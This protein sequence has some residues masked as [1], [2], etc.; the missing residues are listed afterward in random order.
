M[1][2]IF[3]GLA[4]GISFIVY[5]L[6]MADTVPYWDSGEFIA[7]SFILGVPHPP[8]SP[9][10]LIIGRVFSMIPFNPDIAFRINLISPVVSA[11]A[12][13]YLYLSTVK[14]ISN[15]RGKIECSMDAIITFGGSLV[16][17]LTF[18]FTDSQ[19]FNA[20]EAEVYGFSTFFTA[21]VVWL[22]LHWAERADE[23]GNERYILII[24]YMIGLATGV[25]LLNLLALPFI[26]LIIYFKKY[27]FSYKGFLITTAITGV[28]YLII[29]TGII[30]GV[31]KIVNAVG[32]E[33]FLFLCLAIMGGMVFTIIKRQFRYALAL[34]SIVLILV[35]YSSYATIFIRSGQQPAI[36]E[37]DPST[38]PRAIAYMEREQYGQMTQFPRR[39]TGLPP[40]HEVVGRPAKGGRNYSASQERKYKSYR[41]DKQWDYFWSY[42]VK[43]MYWR[44]FLWQ[45]AGRGPSTDDWVTAYGANTKEDGVDWF[46]FGLPLAFLFGLWGMF[47][48]FQKDREQAFSV[49]SLFL[50]MGLAIIIFVNQDN[51][52]PRER[53]YSYVGSFFAFSIWISIAVAALGDKIRLLLKDKSLSNNAVMG[54][55][56]LLIVAMPGMM[57]KANYHEHD[58]SDN[59]LAWDYS[60]NILQSCEPN[61]I[62]FTN[63]DNDTFPLW[64]LQEV[65][66]V[67]TDITIANLSLL[68][69]EWYIRQLR[70]SRRGRV[71][72]KGREL[73][74][75]INLTD[76]QVMEV[77]SGLQPWKA[78]NV[79]IPTPKSNKNKDG[80]IQWKVNPTFAGAALM[81]KD[82]MI[83]KII[84]DAQ[85]NYPIYFAV[86]VPASNRL[87]L[88][89]FL[90]MEGLVYRLRPH[91]VDGRNP[92]NEERMWTN[93]MSG[94]GS[95]IWEQ[96]LE[97]N[98][99]NKVENE[100][101]SKSYKPGYLF[102][103]LGREDVFYF[104][105]TNIRLLQNLRSAY[106]QLAAFH[107]M[108]FKD[109]EMTDKDQS[110]IHR[111]KALEVLVKM[112]DNIPEK[113][114]R[115]DSKDLYYQV[116]RLFGELGNKD[117]LRRILG[118]L[119][120]REDLNIRD[121]LDY[122]QVYISQLDSFEIGQSIFE[123][124]YRDFKDIE[125]GDRRAT[126][127]EM[128]AWRQSFTQI[129]SSLVFTYK[130][131]DM[132]PKAEVVLADWL[133]KNPN[134]PVA[135]KLMEDLKNEEVKSKKE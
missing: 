75:F 133:D 91:N 84:S 44:Y 85:W 32:L 72:Q 103:N 59:R 101:W 45:F 20:V 130:K 88:E 127:K 71:D 39:F 56:V 123:D 40:K 66:G 117:E 65:E 58:R 99:W 105:T 121:R 118:N 120:I 76:P 68:N 53:D 83:L 38:V 36:N 73:E 82:M 16:G 67:R 132:V 3:A 9:L 112:Q 14:L 33:L 135:Q 102:R 69:T 7:T 92:I 106:M 4:L 49:F 86:T 134:D 10:Y 64:Y 43:K 28:I 122:G 46:Q 81:V 60:Y 62:L 27:E 48:H 11:L 98:D 116:G 97:A 80:F 22:I 94:Y 114:I 50:M 89:P 108:A 35:G 115:Y 8:G 37:N 12:V 2:R 51:P 57:V 26:A 119:V 63:G 107:Y 104:P 47:Y 25:H 87:G 41:M 77:A 23:K 24:A 21:I 79:Q 124:L 111:N 131:L 15:Y 18:A 17:A 110:D 125:N 30:N 42:Q 95:E 61:A 55:M 78:R 100:I 128:D 5:L 52:Q 13:M 129:V 93:L 19:W 126:Q 6:T 29:N 109:F 34:T 74:R 70:D 96:D 90:E 31:P 1:N 113:T 54:T